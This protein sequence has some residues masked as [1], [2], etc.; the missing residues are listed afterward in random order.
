[1]F[2]SHINSSELLWTVKLCLYPFTIVIVDMSHF[3]GDG[4]L[5]YIAHNNQKT[6][7][8]FADNRAKYNRALLIN[9]LKEWKA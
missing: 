7:P 4:K 9:P 8:S 1:M 6:L 5:I 3:H 2:S